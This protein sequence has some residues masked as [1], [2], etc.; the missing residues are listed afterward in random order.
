MVLSLR[1]AVI[2]SILSQV[3]QAAPITKTFCGGKH[4]EFEIQ[5]KPPRK[6]Q[7]YMISHQ[8]SGGQSASTQLKVNSL[9]DLTDAL[10]RAAFPVPH[11]FGSPSQYIA[12][13]SYDHEKKLASFTIHNDSDQFD[14]LPRRVKIVAKDDL[15]SVE[16]STIDQILG[17]Q[18]RMVPLTSSIH[19]FKIALQT[20]G[21]DVQNPV[22]PKNLEYYNHET[23]KI[24]MDAGVRDFNIGIYKSYEQLSQT[25]QYERIK[26]AFNVGAEQLKIT[27]IYDGPLT[28]LSCHICSE[29]KDLKWVLL[30][31]NKEL[32]TLQ[33]GQKLSNIESSIL[34]YECSKNSITISGQ[35]HRARE[36]SELQP[37][38][39]K[40]PYTGVEIDSIIPISISSI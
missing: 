18:S 21:Y 22:V 36:S 40:N 10:N 24:P 34:C 25:D 4:I 16:V 9:G 32:E 28:Q 3:L 7:N 33:G 19:N 5:L 12:F 13:M 6:D 15:I 35:S 23:T 31:T 27:D 2:M 38:T 26:K 14:S 20:Q 11:R 8:V 29:A 30:L 39:P 17:Q 37:F 1:V